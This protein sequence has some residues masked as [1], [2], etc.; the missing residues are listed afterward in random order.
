MTAG[1]KHRVALTRR[2]AT[3]TILRDVFGRLVIA[4]AAC[5]LLQLAPASS[6][7]WDT[8]SPARLDRPGRVRSNGVSGL[9]ELVSAW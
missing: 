1:H 6:V 5:V 8:C 9:T 2:P 3:Q 4:M 7:K